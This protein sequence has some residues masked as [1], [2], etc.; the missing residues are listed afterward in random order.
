M[1]SLLEILLGA[2]AV[3]CLDYWCS[4]HRLRSG[5]YSARE[6]PIK[7][8]ALNTFRLRATP[9]RRPTCFLNA[10][11]RISLTTNIALRNLTVC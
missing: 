5:F 1:T 10:S 11:A 6:N 3:L 2:E 7:V 4:E 9:I 8:D